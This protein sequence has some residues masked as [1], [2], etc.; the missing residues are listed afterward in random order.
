MLQSPSAPVRPSL[1]M[2][3]LAGPFGVRKA[4][5]GSTLLYSLA[6]LP[7]ALLLRNPVAGPNPLLVGAALGC[8]FI[9]GYVANRTSRMMPAIVAHALFT[10]AVVE[11]P[12]W[13]P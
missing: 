5:V 7:T 13:R 11:F 10:W 2:P 8:G 4:W 12:I 6:H 3:V 9:W 1:V